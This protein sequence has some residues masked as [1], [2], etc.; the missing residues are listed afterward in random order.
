MTATVATGAATGPAA[1]RTKTAQPIYAHIPA[2]GALTLLTVVT[3]ISLCRVFPDWAYLR[4]M[5]VVCIG[6]HAVMCLLR[7]L[8]VSA[9]SPCPSGW[10]RWPF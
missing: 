8:K 1:V 6:V 3:A 10:S 4:P 2:T 9:G 5:L 7:V